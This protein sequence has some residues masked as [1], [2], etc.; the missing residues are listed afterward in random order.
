MAIT[1]IPKPARKNNF[2]GGTDVFLINSLYAEANPEGMAWSSH[3]Y[4]ALG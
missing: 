3:G 1:K 2:T 4:S